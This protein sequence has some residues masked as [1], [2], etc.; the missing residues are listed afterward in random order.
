MDQAQKEAEEAWAQSNIS[1][2]GY[3]AAVALPMPM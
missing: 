1:S 3:S 2:E